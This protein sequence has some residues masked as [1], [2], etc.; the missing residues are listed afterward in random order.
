MTR[1][2]MDVTYIL[3]GSKWMTVVKAWVAA[4]IILYGTS[5][6][7]VVVGWMRTYMGF[8]SAGFDEGKRKLS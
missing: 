6:F 5:G 1:K 3:Y 4:W 2:R 8:L 7:S